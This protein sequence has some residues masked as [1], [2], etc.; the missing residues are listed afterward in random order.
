MNKA[1]ASIDISNTNTKI[2]KVTEMANSHSNAREATVSKHWQGKTSPKFEPSH[3]AANTK[4][5]NLIDT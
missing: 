2:E 5:N 1:S 3:A 4:R